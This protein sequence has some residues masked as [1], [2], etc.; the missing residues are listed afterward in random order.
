MHFNFVSHIVET[1]RGVNVS[2]PSDCVNPNSDTIEFT[3]P[4]IT[5]L[6]LKYSSPFCTSTV[7]GGSHISV[8]RGAHPQQMQN[9]IAKFYKILISSNFGISSSR[10]SDTDVITK[11]VQ[12]ISTQSSEQSGSSGKT[13]N[14]YYGAV[15]FE[16][17][18]RHCLS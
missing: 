3:E 1:G 18:L 17:R 11:H 10:I 4:Q 6:Y 15:H 16:L 12:P 5:S 9:K 7:S 13:S 2:T 8:S 14:P